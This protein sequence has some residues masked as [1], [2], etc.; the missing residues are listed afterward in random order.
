MSAHFQAK[1]ENK[2][3]PKHLKAFEMLGG[4]QSGVK[5]TKEYKDAEQE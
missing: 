3:S 4:Q 1:F 2:E 5:L